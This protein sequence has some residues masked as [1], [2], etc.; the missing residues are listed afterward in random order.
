MISVFKHNDPAA[1][2]LGM[3]EGFSDKH[4]Y[5]RMTPQAFSHFT[6]HQTAGQ[7]LVMDVQGVGDVYTDPQIVSAQG[8]LYGAGLDNGMVG[9]LLFSCS[10]SVAGSPVLLTMRCGSLAGRFFS[11]IALFV[12]PILPALDHL[13]SPFFHPWRAL[14]SLEASVR[15]PSAQSPWENL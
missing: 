3:L 4:N 7:R 5:I 10:R 8:D 6:Y 12:P 1:N 11:A 13:V 15:P 2:I 14:Y 9:M